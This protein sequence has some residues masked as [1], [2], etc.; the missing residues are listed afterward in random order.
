VPEVE[1][2]TISGI[3]DGTDDEGGR[4]A[5][6]FANGKRGSISANLGRKKTWTTR[7]VHIRRTRWWYSISPKTRSCVGGVYSHI[8][9]QETE[10][11]SLS[12]SASASRN[13]MDS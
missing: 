4:M 13:L 10:S 8:G 7:K 12:L 5:A 11:E 1:I 6:L 9:S 3:P 2:R